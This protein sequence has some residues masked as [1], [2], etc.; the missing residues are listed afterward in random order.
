MLVASSFAA[1]VAHAE[2]LAPR[3]TFAKPQLQTISNDV[4]KNVVVLKMV[5]GS[6]VRLRNQTLNFDPSRLTQDDLALLKRNGLDPQAAAKEV[7]Q[8]QQLLAGISDAA[9]QRYFELPEEKLAKQ[10]AEA[11]AL[12]KEEMAD[13]DTYFAWVISKPQNDDVVLKILSV[14]NSLKVVELAYLPPKAVGAVVT[15]DLSAQQGYRVTSPQGIDA[16]YAWGFPGGRGEGIKIVDVE[17]G[18]NLD[19]EDLPARFWGG[20][21]GFHVFI[22]GD[23][24]EH[25]TAVVG[26]MVGKDNGSG[27]QG[28]SP[29]AAIGMSSVVRVAFSPIGAAISIGA[30]ALNR[31]DVLLVEQHAHGPSTGMACN[32]AAVEGNCPQW[33]YI[34]QEYWSPDYDA[35]KTATA[36]GIVVVEAAGNGGMNLDSPIYEGRFNRAIRNSGAILVGG[37]FAGNRNAHGWSNYGSRVDVQGWG[38]SVMTTGYGMAGYQYGGSGDVNR[39]YT[40]GFSGTSSASPVVAGAVAS[41][42]GILRAR[43]MPVLTSVG[44]A[45]LLKATGRPQPMA[46]AA[47]RAIGPLPNLKFALDR[48]FNSAANFLP[49]GLGRPYFISPEYSSGMAFTIPYLAT[50]NGTHIELWNQAAASGSQAFALNA[51]AGGYYEIRS[52]FSGKCVEVLSFIR[53]NNAEIGEWDCWG[54]DNQQ[55]MIAPITGDAG[56]YTITNKFT[57]KSLDAYAWGTAD[58]TRLTQWDYHGGTNQRFHFDPWY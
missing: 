56:A 16:N 27:V 34:A 14:L 18:W 57:G 41:L 12:S 6:K 21:S 38:D 35:I 22:P 31:G 47:T 20:N 15:P 45:N 28:I 52:V 37:G 48:L 58:R 10:K 5:E 53:E 1:S 32:S 54:G 2:V 49:V 23:Q 29:A 36:R 43:G 7:L 26:V 33:E 25:G 46:T 8:V 4:F 40:P 24:V 42:Q 51:T 9:L 39:F 11:E 17:C 13:L 30:D 55:W 44:M 19:H 50:A 3:V